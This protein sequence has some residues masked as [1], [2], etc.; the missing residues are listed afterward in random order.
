MVSFTSPANITVISPRRRQ[1]L[2]ITNSW[3]SLSGAKKRGH[4]GKRMHAT[5]EFSFIVA[6]KTRSGPNPSKL[7]S[8]K[9][10]RGAFWYVMAPISPSMELPKVRQSLDLIDRAV[11]RGGTKKVFVV[12][13]RSNNR[14]GNG[15]EW[16]Y[17]ATVTRLQSL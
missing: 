16:R 11:T 17:C 6:A 5:V 14:E 13:T 9:E 3:Q 8:L 4:P 1:I 2:P 7:K 12:R 15:T 10:E